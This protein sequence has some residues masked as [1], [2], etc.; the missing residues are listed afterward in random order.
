[1]E[2]NEALKVLESSLAH[3]KW[4][5]K[6]HAYRRLQID[7]LALCTGMRPVIMVDY[8][9][10]M[11]ELQE[12]LCTLL[13]HCQKG[14]PCFE[15][16]SVMIIDDMIYLISVRGLTE[17]VRLSLNSEA[18]LL[19]VDLEH[20]PPK[21]IT[22][23]EGNSL[24]MELAKVQKLFSSFFPSEG[25]QNDLSLAMGTDNMA[26]VES[27]NNER[28][29]SPSPQF[30]D[31]SSC[32]EN[33]LITVPTLNGWLLGYPI[34]YLFGKEHISG[35]IYNLSAKFL[36]IYNISVRR[37]GALDKQW[38]PSELLSFTVPYGLSMGGSKEPWA[39]AFLARLRSKLEKC[40]QIWKS[41]EM[42]DVYDC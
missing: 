31:L 18:E 37:T 28:V 36:R 40:K 34:V 1:M 24:V 38:G 27:S 2:F 4:R 14:S 29:T 20:D 23:T 6:S 5:L 19:F 11:P 3:I 13:K 42:E 32:M 30:V 21:M 9:G 7:I 12:R 17:H 10:K 33:T 26:F 15:D 8:G 25:M 39:E 41:L 22:Q 16:L 35:A